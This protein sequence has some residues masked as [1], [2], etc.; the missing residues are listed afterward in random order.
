VQDAAGTVYNFA[1]DRTS[2]YELSGSTWNTVGTG[3][4]A[5]NWEFVKWGQRV[6][7]TAPNTNP[8][9]FDLGVSTTFQ[10]LPNAPQA[11]RVAV[12]RDFVV[13]AGLT[14]DP[15]VVKWSGFNNSEYWTPDLA[16]QSDEQVLRGRGGRIQ[17]IVP[18]DV[19]TVF[20]EHSIWRA[21]Y[22]GPPTLF[23]FDEVERG[24]GT[25]AP[26]SV[27]WTGQYIFYYG[28]DGFYSFTDQSQPIG[29]NRVDRW[30]AQ[31]A[32]Q[33][34]L[35]TMRGAVDR[36]NRLVM[37]GFKSTS[38][39]PLNDRVIIYNWGADKW[40]YGEIDSQVISEYLTEGLT[41]EQAAV[42]FGANSDAINILSDSDAFAGGRL[43]LALFG[44][45]NRLQVLSGVP[46]DYEIDTTEVGENRRKMVRSVRPLVDG[47]T[48]VCV[49]TR[50]RLRDQVSLGVPVPQNALGE[51]PMNQDARYHRFR[52]KGSGSFTHAQ[53]VEIDYRM[54]GRQ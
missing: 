29:A 40:S 42:V 54:S 7:T 45:G 17:R 33:S 51:C 16:F 8:Q 30:F 22:V 12:T 24:R 25:P 1:G 28:Q 14:T 4:G 26:N 5:V 46:L 43:S 34:V 52:V 41:L 50:N 35:D 32:D 27:C 13:L 9:Y 47:D 10:D 15:E 36:Q 18:G 49:M 2:L 11:S 38:S 31:E 3:Y 39:A 6:I 19:L 20:Q 44:D 21:A 37:W 23:R 48:S 53:G